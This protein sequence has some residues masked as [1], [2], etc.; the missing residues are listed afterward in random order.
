MQPSLQLTKEASDP[1]ES[2][3]AHKK[4]E[5]TRWSSSQVLQ[6]GTVTRKLTEGDSRNFV[7]QR[8]RDGRPVGTQ[9]RMLR[10]RVLENA[11]L[12]NGNIE[13]TEDS[14]SSRDNSCDTSVNQVKDADVHEASCKGS[15][16]SGV[17]VLASSAT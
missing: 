2:G 12:T 15:V 9:Q 5:N 10:P 4:V 11:L 14:C 17:L 6:D 7:L 3:K 16:G 1:K 8:E 13:L